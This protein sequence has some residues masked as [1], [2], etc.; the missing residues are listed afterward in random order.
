MKEHI[1]KFQRAQP[2]S[3]S[4]SYKWMIKVCQNVVEAERLE[5]IS[6]QRLENSKSNAADPVTPGV[7]EGG[8]K[9]KSGGKGKDG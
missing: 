9:G 1:A 4:Q 2:R 5:R 8:G 3:S 7:E 6:R